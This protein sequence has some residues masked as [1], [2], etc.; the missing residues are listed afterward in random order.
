MTNPNQE[1]FIL[2]ATPDFVEVGQDFAGVPHMTIVRWFTRTAQ[3]ADFID[4]V[5]DRFSQNPTVFEGVIGAKHAM[6]GPNADIPVRELDGVSVWPYV[7]MLQA[8]KSRGG[9]FFGEDYADEFSP[10]ITDTPSRQ[11]QEGELVRFSSIAIVR[12][13]PERT[14]K[15]VEAAFP[16]GQE[17]AE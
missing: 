15:T 13:N 5:Q 9:L 6:Y 12:R 4:H 3:W 10:H 14:V 1:K 11:I 2:A 17:A 16:L 8:I 7:S